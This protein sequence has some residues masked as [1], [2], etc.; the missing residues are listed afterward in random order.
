[1][2]SH[3]LRNKKSQGK[4]DFLHIDFFVV[5]LGKVSTWTFCK[6]IL[7]V[8]LNSPYREMPKKVLKKVKENKFGRLVGGSGI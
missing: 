5:F 7:M 4:N 3:R 6:N 1:L 2:N 8:F